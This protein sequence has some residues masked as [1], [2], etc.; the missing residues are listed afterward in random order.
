MGNQ[1]IERY[2]A[3]FRERDKVIRGLKTEKSAN[4]YM[5]NWK[6]YYNFV[7]PHMTFKGL[8]PSEVAGISIGTERNKWM[9]LLKLSQSNTSQ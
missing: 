2:H 8:T 4:Q 9:G 7:K 1:I 3:T 6:T 5:K